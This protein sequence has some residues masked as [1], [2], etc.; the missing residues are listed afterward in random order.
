MHTELFE[1]FAGLIAEIL[2]VN[3]L[4]T[5]QV[6]LIEAGSVFMIM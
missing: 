1:W 6:G 2:Y 5:P 4:H 3:I